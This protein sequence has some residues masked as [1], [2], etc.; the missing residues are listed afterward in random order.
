MLTAEDK[1]KILHII[2]RM[3]ENENKRCDRICRINEGNADFCRDRRRDRSIYSS[4]LYQLYNIIN[5]TM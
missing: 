4:A 2:N 5:D 1:N 3:Q